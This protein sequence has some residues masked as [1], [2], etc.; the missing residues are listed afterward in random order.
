[1]RTVPRVLAG[2][3]NQGRLDGL[4]FHGG[5]AHAMRAGAA[6]RAAACVGEAAVVWGAAARGWAA[7]VDGAAAR[8]GAAGV[9]GAARVWR[10]GCVKQT[11]GMRRSRCALCHC[12]HTC[13][14]L[15]GIAGVDGVCGAVGVER[16]THRIMQHAKSAKSVYSSLLIMRGRAAHE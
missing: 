9:D 5:S 6:P 2:R 16:R 3:S 15:I 12:H 14:V 7:R 10:A 1:M 8:C 4:A 11:T 13:C